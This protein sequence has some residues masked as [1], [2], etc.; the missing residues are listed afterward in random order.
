MANLLRQHL[1]PTVLVLL[2]VLF[3][4]SAPS[5]S[6]EG[7]L[8]LVIGN[9]AYAHMEPVETAINDVTDVSAALSEAGFE[10]ILGQDLTL[11]EMRK[12]IREFAVKAA[13]GKSITAALIFYAG[14]GIQVGGEMF[15]I[16]IDAKISRESQLRLQAL[17]LNELSTATK[18]APLALWSVIIDAPRT[19]PLPPSLADKKRGVVSYVPVNSIIAYSTSPNG[20]VVKASGRNSYFTTALLKVMKHRGLDLESVFSKVRQNVFCATDG[21]QIPWENSSLIQRFNFFPP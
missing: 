3:A 18:S 17:S 13:N 4:L 14:Q 21:R 10:V 1:F 7:R 19:N 15:L 5:A 8:A 9:R 16:P 2:A 12:T 20:Q 11:A 6:A